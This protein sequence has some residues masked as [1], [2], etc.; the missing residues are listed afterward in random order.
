[1]NEVLQQLLDFVKSASPQVWATL[2]RQVYVDAIMDI[3]WAVILIA[4]AVFLY[5]LAKRCRAEQ[6]ETDSFSSDEAWDMA[7]ISS[8]VGMGFCVLLTLV[9]LTAAMPRFANPEF[10][11]IRWLASVLDSK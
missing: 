9:M 8:Y 5:L 11:A 1:M 6:E 4:A 3:V 7:A 2:V 10:Y